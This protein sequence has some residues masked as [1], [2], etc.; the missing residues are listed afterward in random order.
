MS[1]FSP[2]SA[3]WLGL[4]S[5]GTTAQLQRAWVEEVAAGER[6]DSLLLLEHTPVITLGRRRGAEQNVIH[7]GPVPVLSVERGGDATWHAPGQL[8]VYPI[9]RVLGAE[10]VDLLLTDILMPDV[11]GI[12]LIMQ[13][14]RSHPELKVIAMSGGGRT[15]AEVLINIAR[16]LGVHAT[17]E[18]PFDLATLLEK[19]E[20][21]VGK[22]EAV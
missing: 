9:L 12:E 11:D 16:R 17:L 21:L 18:K 20:S 8:V 2:I 4:Q 13:V 15:A 14:R 6:P 19:I 3:H 5:Y 1:Q 7:A 22:P 10:A